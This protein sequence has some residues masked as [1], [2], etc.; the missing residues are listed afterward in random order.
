MTRPSLRFPQR[1]ER[2][3]A[4]SGFSGITGWDAATAGMPNSCSG[5]S[6]TERVSM[7]LSST[8]PTTEEKDKLNE[9]R[10]LALIRDLDDGDLLLLNAFA[11][12]AEEKPKKF[13]KLRPEPAMVGSPSEVREAEELYKASIGRL[14]RLSLI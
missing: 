8:L 5:S 13:A 10:V 4:I 1:Q 6:A 3:Q 12:N 7:R 14:E 2:S 11:S 9:K